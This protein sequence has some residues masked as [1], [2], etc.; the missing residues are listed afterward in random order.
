MRAFFPLEAS[1]TMVMG[2]WF[3]R[4]D[5]F[6]DDRMIVG[7][8]SDWDFRQ[9]QTPAH[10]FSGPQGFGRG[11]DIGPGIVPPDC[12]G[13]VPPGCPGTVLPMGLWRPPL[14]AQ[15]GH[16]PTSNIPKTI[17]CH[18]APLSRQAAE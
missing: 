1:Q 10:C 7:E 5:D 11:C 2:T 12:P 18:M 13:I 3:R 9:G 15:S 16:T 6:A 8:T 17:I 14:H 4:N